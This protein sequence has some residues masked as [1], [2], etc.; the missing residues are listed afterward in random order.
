MKMGFHPKWVNLIMDGISFVSYSVLVKGVPSSYIRPFKGIRPG[1][2]L[3]PHLFLLCSKGFSALLRN[4]AQHRYLHGVSISWSG[5]QITHLLFANDSLLFCSASLFECHIIKEILHIYELTS[6]QKNKLWQNLHFFS[7]NS[8]FALREDIRLF[9]NATS[10]VSLEKYLR[11]PLIIGRGK[12]Q[13]F[14]EIKNRIQS[15]LCGWKGKL[16]TQTGREI[17]IKLVAQAI[18]VY[19]MNCFL[20]LLGLY[21]EINSMMGQFWWGRKNEEKKMHWL[22]WKHLCLAK[23]DGGLGFQDLKCFNLALLA[24]Q[25]WRL[26]NN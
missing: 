1:D 4:A 26:L 15:K 11:L 18:P 7:T 8:P 20:L 22:S 5:P 13:T 16:L 3:S 9:L 24:K 23:K 10:N 21:D 25:C 6:G 12:K 14:V 2:P 19:A 17:L